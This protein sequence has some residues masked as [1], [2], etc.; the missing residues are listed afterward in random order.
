MQDICTTATNPSDSED[1]EQL[2]LVGVVPSSTD[3]D[4]STNMKVSS[5]QKRASV[6]TESVV[7]EGNRGGTRRQLSCEA[8]E[9]T[10]GSK[11]SNS[12]KDLHDEVIVVGRTS[13]EKREI[14]TAPK[15]DCDLQG[16][17]DPTCRRLRHEAL[18]RISLQ[19]LGQIGVE[20]TLEGR[21]RKQEITPMQ[22]EEHEWTNG[23][24]VPSLAVPSDVTLSCNLRNASKKGNEE[25]STS[26][27]GKRKS[28]VERI[29]PLQSKRRR[30]NHTTN[31]R[32]K[33]NT[34]EISLEEVH[35][36]DI[37]DGRNISKQELWF[38]QLGEKE[39]IE[40]SS[41]LGNHV[42]VNGHLE[43]NNNNVDS[44]GMVL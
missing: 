17:K 38:E 36:H 35:S 14:A 12:D 16:G 34:K 3:S 39:D 10:D 33:R 25:Q 22:L 9:R 2:L 21:E 37:E 20:S 28:K 15:G 30:Q 24:D 6:S 44:K 5:P 11:I 7:K 26:H 23:K 13:T 29:G 42:D 4:E 19:N 8:Q 41:S 32:R 18:E 1:E 40:T 27:A 31:S 43:T